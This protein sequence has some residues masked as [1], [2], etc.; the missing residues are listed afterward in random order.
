MIRWIIACSLANLISVGKNVQ[1]GTAYV[2]KQTNVPLDSI[3]KTIPSTSPSQCLLKCRRSQWCSRVGM[4]VEGDTTPVCVHLSGDE[5]DAG[6]CYGD[7]C[8]GL[9][10]LEEVDANMKI[11]K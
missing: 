2:E 4:R 1:A 8:I 11:S 6:G 10:L 7:N 5:I 3:L 9:T